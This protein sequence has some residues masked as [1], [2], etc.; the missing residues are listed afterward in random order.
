MIWGEFPVL[1]IVI[2]EVFHHIGLLLSDTVITLGL[3]HLSTVP[4]EM[5][6]LMYDMEV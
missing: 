3:R 5:Y 6:M 1:L 4:S 2:F